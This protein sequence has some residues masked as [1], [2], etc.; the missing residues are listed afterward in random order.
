MPDF[1][2]SEDLS[3]IDPDEQVARVIYASQS[4]VTGPIYTELERIRAAALRNNVP[5]HVFTALL[6]QSGWF[7]QW[8]EGPEEAIR[9]LMERVARDS[10]H[11]G[12]R[13][14][15]A[16]F[17][18]R[19]LAG[20]WSMAVV[21][22]TERFEEMGVRVQA[23]QTQL[24][25]GRQEAPPSVWR[26][27]S[28]PASHAGAAHQ[29]REG[30]FHRVMVVAA[31]G[32]LSFDLVQWLAQSYRE[33]LVHRRFAGAHDL[34]VGTDYVDIDDDGR[35]QRVIAMSRRGLSVP[36]TRA[37]LPD[38]AHIL[39]LLSGEPRFDEAIMQRLARACA[40]AAPPPVLVG[41]ATDTQVL[42][43]AG[44]EA[45]R[46]GLDWRNVQA[47]PYD[48]AGTW[49]AASALWDGFAPPAPVHVAPATG[50]LLV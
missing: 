34:D 44:R 2:I 14:V 41:I 47:D 38:Y 29:D 21:Q 31:T 28:T 32:M 42:A 5:L 35:L 36:L 18:P 48:A 45:H 9:G 6:H 10:R 20:P 11:A 40:H 22:S 7:V 27:L 16:S 37:F 15:H 25:G 30:A 1:L 8:K 17:G 23:L 39:V 49:R 19:L 24:S 33:P 46:L 26:R 3:Q 12:L 13:M 50:L 4:T 43:R